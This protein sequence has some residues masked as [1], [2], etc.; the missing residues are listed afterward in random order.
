MLLLPVI[1]R[2]FG[3]I[4]GIASHDVKLQLIKSKCFPVLSPITVWK[5]MPFAKV[6]ILLT[7][8]FRKILNTRS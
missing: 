7:F 1:Q 6:T 8:T 3:K 5:P 4:G 2:R